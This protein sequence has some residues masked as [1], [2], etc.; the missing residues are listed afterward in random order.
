MISFFI[1]LAA[2]ASNASTK[3]IKFKALSLSQPEIE[4]GIKNSKGKIDVFT[5]YAHALS[6]EK[7]ITTSERKI[8]LLMA[9]R[10]LS[11]KINWSTYATADVPPDLDSVILILSGDANHPKTTIVADAPEQSQG[12][13]LRFLNACP[14]PVGINLP[15]FKKIL[16][17]GTETLC[18]PS[19][20]HETYGQGQLFT[21]NTGGGWRPAGGMRWLQLNDVRTLWFI[22]PDPNNESLV[23][24]HGI[25]ESVR[26]NWA[27][28]TLKINP[29]NA[30][31][32]T[33][34]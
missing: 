8:V 19:I 4:I 27:T 23:T 17:S 22:A 1:A 9:D 11:G 14:Y 25:E 29:K 24:V 21:S 30:V 26:S 20:K 16:A 2:L 28:P 5:V 32:Q 33:D 31:S 18:K 34:R 3:E 13:S 10:S 12:G 15:G 7:V 6:S